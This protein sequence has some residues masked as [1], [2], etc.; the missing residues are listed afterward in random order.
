M[1]PVT[2]GLT[3]NV[4]RVSNHMSKL[5]LEVLVVVGGKLSH[6]TQAWNIFCFI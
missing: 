2:E 5:Y 1:N 3:D 6:F 4:D